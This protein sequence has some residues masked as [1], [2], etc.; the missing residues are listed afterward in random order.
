MEVKV[1]TII[2]S[3]LNDFAI[4]HDP[5]RLEFVKYLVFSYTD[6]SV[7]INPTTVWRTWYDSRQK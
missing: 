1:R 5:L 7:E 4:D 6:T 3:H 2:L